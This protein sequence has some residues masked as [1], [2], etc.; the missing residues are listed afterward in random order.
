MA[1]KDLEQ[2][3]GWRSGGQQQ[4]QRRPAGELDPEF[5]MAG[6]DVPAGKRLYAS[7]D[8]KGSKFQVAIDSHTH[9]ADGWFLTSIMQRMLVVTR[10]TYGE[11]M[12]EV[13]RIWK[14]W[15]DEDDHQLTEGRHDLPALPR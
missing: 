7:K 1:G 2:V 8:L 15:Q 4:Q 14:N 11:A 10:P 12:A 3:R 6:V 13:I 5:I 9:D